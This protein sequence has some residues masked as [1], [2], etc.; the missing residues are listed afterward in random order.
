VLALYFTS[1]VLVQI[2]LASNMLS[3]LRSGERAAGAG[4]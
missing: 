2:E 4:M 1:G 3:A